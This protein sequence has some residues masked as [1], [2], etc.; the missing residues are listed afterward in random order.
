[1][2]FSPEMLQWFPILIMAVIFYF[3]L[4]RP[5]K[6]QQKKRDQMLAGLKKGE[7]IVTVGG[8]HGT[9]TGFSGDMLTLRIAEKVEIEL[10]RTAVGQVYTPGKSEDK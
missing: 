3:F 7:R 9:I 5:Q 2:Q 10:N 8:I 6:N 4:Y 1:M